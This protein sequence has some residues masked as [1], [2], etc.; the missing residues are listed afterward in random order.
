MFIKEVVK[1]TG[2]TRKAIE[3]YTLQKIIFPKIL[4]N[5]YREYSSEDV[6][7]LKKVLVLRKLNLSIQ[8]IKEILKDSTN[9]YLRSVLVKKELELARDEKKKAILEQ[10][11]NGK[12]YKDIE[13]DLK[14]IDNEKNIIDKLIE[15]YPGYYGQFIGMHF[16]AFLNEP[17]KTAVQ[18]KAYN[19]IVSFL[20]NLEDLDIPKDLEEFLN[21]NTKFIGANHMKDIIENSKNIYDK[22]KE[23][24]EENK[25]MLRE[26]MEF[27]KT[28]EYKNSPATKLFEIIK[29]FNSKKGY[30]EIFIPALRELS[31]S[32]NEYYL[33]VEK[34]NQE[35]LKQFPSFK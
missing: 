16:S 14:A 13:I 3:Y 23:F 8:D 12:S 35:F 17:I 21:E 33:K 22:P 18:D 30:N 11:Y 27:K 4:E 25:E 15:A 1:K 26:Y 28:D 29:E 9:N 5:G 10:L 20:D 24:L 7:V 6:E 31:D 32:Y 34:A 19:T 2:L